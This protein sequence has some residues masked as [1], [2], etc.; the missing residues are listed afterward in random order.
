MRIQVNVVLGAAGLLLSALTGAY[1][2]GNWRDLTGLETWEAQFDSR[3]VRFPE[4]AAA[5][6]PGAKRTE[7]F[8]VRNENVSLVL[9][10]LGWR[11][12]A[13]GAPEV[14]VR[15]K[16]PSGRLRAE[17]RHTG[18]ASGIH[19]ELELIAPDDVPRGRATF[20]ATASVAGQE[21]EE[22]WPSRPEG[23]GNWTVE[24][25]SRPP[26]AGPSGDII[27]GLRITYD[28]YAGTFA[29]AP[30]AVR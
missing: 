27:F 19:L 9:L 26:A 17:D 7:T 11:D 23:R 10:D 2:A 14:L 30:A 12:P 4:R 15:L 1:V 20:S 21:F 29:R 13:F 3:T 18:G 24:L 6:A 16:D 22:R 5:L 25:E 28:H 8:L